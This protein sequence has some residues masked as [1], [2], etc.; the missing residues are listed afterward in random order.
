MSQSDNSFP[1][2]IHIATGR[3]GE[4]PTAKAS[5]PSPSIPSSNALYSTPTKDPAPRRGILKSPSY[6]FTGHRNGAQEVS[7]PTTVGTNESL[8]NLDDNMSQSSSCGSSTI[9]SAGTLG[10][11]STE[12]IKNAID[13]I[14]RD[15]SNNNNKKSNGGDNTLRSST[16]IASSS[17]SSTSMTTSSS[18]ASVVSAKEVVQR[19][20]RIKHIEDLNER[21]NAAKARILVERKAYRREDKLLLR[22]ARQLKTISKS[23]RENAN[24]TQMLEESNRFCEDRYNLTLQELKD[25]ISYRSSLE[26]RLLA[27]K[28]IKLADDRERRERIIRV[29]NAELE[30]HKRSH[31]FWCQTLCESILEANNELDRFRALSGEHA[32]RGSSL[33]KREGENNRN[34]RRKKTSRASQWMVMMVVLAIAAL[35]VLAATA[36]G[37]DRK[38]TSHSFAG[39]SLV[40]PEIPAEQQQE[41]YRSLP[42]Q[43]IIRSGII[44]GENTA[45]GDRYSTTQT[46]ITIRNSKTTISKV[47][48]STTAGIRKNDFSFLQPAINSSSFKSNSNEDYNAINTKTSSTYVPSLTTEKA[49]TKLKG[50]S[51][52]RFKPKEAVVSIARLFRK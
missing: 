44:R 4:S 38:T 43:S 7:T 16:S 28:Q 11:T 6:K 33:L 50:K 14:I 21:I 32:G 5:R 26:E 30:A 51:G 3:Q 13:R 20:A 52:H 37:R 25:L 46:I 48:T 27:E 22:L 2:F 17:T 35:V 36:G 34:G 1:E 40:Q 49:T 15:K 42:P 45:I 19:S 23:C 31:R 39:G 10:T 9:G 12:G 47:S 29:Q 18:T 8:D 24:N 41:Q